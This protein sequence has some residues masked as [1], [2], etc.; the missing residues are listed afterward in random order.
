MKKTIF[1]ILLFSAIG[2]L[3]CRKDKVQPGIKDVDQQQILDYIST[4]NITG[5]KRDT[6]GGDTSG[7]YYE[8]ILPGTPGTSYKYAD[9]VS[10]AFSLSSFDGNYVSADT[11]QNHYDDFAGHITNK[12]LPYGLELVIHDVL[13]RG[14]SMRILIPSRLAYGVNGYGTG[15]RLNVNSRI[16][17]NQC[18]DYYI[19]SI[20]NEAAYDDQVIKNYLTANNFTGYQK[21]ASGLYYLLRTPGTGTDPITDNTTISCVYT[22]LM[23]N[24]AIVDQFNSTDGTTTTFDIPDLIPGMR[25]G[26]KNYVTTGASVS[27]IIPSTLAYRANAFGTAPPN[28]ILR[29]EM[30]ITAVT[31]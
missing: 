14:G 25:E 31:P 3:S 11:I 30:N 29:Y 13:K 1:T 7:I 19:H 22:A 26:L 2:L 12:A 21:T 9:S 15:S 8:T 10:F 17:G 28:T 5:M 16:A 18:L 27:F 24:G 20:T 23:L 6:V 4:H